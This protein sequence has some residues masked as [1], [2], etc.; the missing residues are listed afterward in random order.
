MV[1]DGDGQQQ[2]W[3]RKSHFSFSL[4]QPFDKVFA[5]FNQLNQRRIENDEV[6]ALWDMI[7]LRIEGVMKICRFREKDARRGECGCAALLVYVA[8]YRR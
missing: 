5:D 2:R 3:Q 7:W 8:I 4:I 1:R 6:W